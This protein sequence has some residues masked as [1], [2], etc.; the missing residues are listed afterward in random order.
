MQTLMAREEG[1]PIPDFSEPAPELLEVYARGGPFFDAFPLLLATQRSIDSLALAAPESQLDVRRFRPNVLI[2]TDR[3]GRFPEQ[4][5]IGRRIR[6]G[7]AILAIQSTCIR[8]V[9][10]THAF[11]DLPKDSRIM[12]TLVREAEGNLGV[13]ATVEEP[14]SIRE[15]DSVLL[16]D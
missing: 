4:G 7:Q 3:P 1:E 14:G 13:Y 16:L 2:D 9:M 10:T 8:C 11:D 12:R 6:I 15:D 5:W